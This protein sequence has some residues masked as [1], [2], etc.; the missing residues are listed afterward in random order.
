MSYP[1]PTYRYRVSIDGEEMAFQNV[2]GLEVN[3]QTMEYKDG[4]G[5]WFQ[6]LGQAGAINITLSRGVFVGQSN[7]YDWI[8]SSSGNQVETK[9]ITITLTN[10]S[11]SEVLVT[12]NVIDAF[13]TRLTAPNFDAAS[14]EVAIE[15]LSL[16][17]KRVSVKFTES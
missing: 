13:P 11:G 4:M 1:I 7:L 8:S 3:Y 17:A 9:D 12:W 14:N 15:E 5:D 16:V 6:M 2:A 10:E